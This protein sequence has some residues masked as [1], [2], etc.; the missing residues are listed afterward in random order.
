MKI[1]KILLKT[2]KACALFYVTLF[3]FAFFFSDSMIFI[4]NVGKPFD[5]KTTGTFR[6][7]V[8]DGGWICAKLFPCPTAKYIV[9]YSHGNGECIADLDFIAEQYNSHGYSFFTY[10][11]RG[12]GGSSGKSS[13]ANAYQD[14]QAA[15]GYLIKELKWQP[16]QIIIHGFSLG[17]GISAE[18]ASKN[19]VAALILDSTFVSAFKVVIPITIL[20]FDTMQTKSKLSLIKCPVLIIHGTRDEIISFWHGKELYKTAKE[21]KE[22]IPVEG[23]THGEAMFLAGDTFWRKLNSL[24]E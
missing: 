12:Y 14:I 9:L 16:E 21:P 15:Y 3:F 20:P 8:P 10:D 7:P 23:A 1:K 4:K 19:K 18:L 24:L 6:I 13:I 2:V 22:F 11:Y 5:E 17:G